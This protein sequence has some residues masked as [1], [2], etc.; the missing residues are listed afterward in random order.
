MSTYA[1]GVSLAGICLL[2]VLIR[3]NPSLALQAIDEMDKLLAD[4]YD[5]LRDHG[6]LAFEDEVMESTKEMLLEAREK[7]RQQEQ[8]NRED[9][10]KR[11]EDST[12]T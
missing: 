7:Q 1:P 5:T 12:R 8:P 10:K 4:G 3:T 11:L 6:M 9:L 2:R